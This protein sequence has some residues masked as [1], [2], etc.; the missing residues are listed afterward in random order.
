MRFRQTQDKRVIVVDGDDASPEVMIPSVAILESLGLPIAFERPLIGAEAKRQVGEYFPDL[1]RAAIDASDATL[2]GSTSGASTQ[3]LF[4]LRWGKQTYANVR[5]CKWIPGFHSPLAHPEGIDFVI[6]REN[7]EGLYLGLEGDIEEL[8]GLNL[9]A[10]N[11]RPAL[12]D[13]GPGKFAIKAIT[14][15]G[16]ERVIR[17]AFELARERGIKNHAAKSKVTVACKY[18]MLHVSDGYFKEI[19][20]DIATE[21]PDIE[22]ETYII[23]DFLCR[24][25]TRPHDFDVIVMPNLYGDIMSDGAAGL[26]GGLGLAPSGCYGDDFA[27]FESAHGSAPDIVGKNIINPTATLLSGAMML[28]YLEFSDA[29]TRLR[30]AVTAVYKEGKLLTPDQ[31]GNATTTAF[32]NAVS[33]QLQ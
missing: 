25:I 3:A 20:G 8:A 13:I 4:Y 30:D 21:Y 2:F 15:R 1:T 6:V 9:P 22:M 24:M 31:G 28:D 14:A 32:C 10:R 19:A 11:G 17:Y 5:P 23:D 27:Y 7:L 12:N 26:I 18:N 33:A 29:A 16:A